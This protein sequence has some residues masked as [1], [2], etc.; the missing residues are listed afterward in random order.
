MANSRVP[1]KTS[2]NALQMRMTMNDDFRIGRYFGLRS[3]RVSRQACLLPILM[4][5]ILVHHISLAEQATTHVAQMGSNAGQG[6]YQSIDRGSPMT[7]SSGKF[8]GTRPRDLR[9]NDS[10]LPP[11]GDPLSPGLVLPRS[12]QPSIT[13]PPATTF[14]GGPIPVET[15]RVTECPLT[16]QSLIG[17]RCYPK[18]C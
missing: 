4:S 6:N 8:L 15:P 7:E 12:T 5:L 16:C 17:T 3:I 1:V 18:I 10:M 2:V 11:S 14:P 13:L 9:P